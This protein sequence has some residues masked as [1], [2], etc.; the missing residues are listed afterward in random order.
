M[1]FLVFSAVILAALLDA[2][3]HV[4]IKGGA[5]PF[6]RS[7][8]VAIAGGVIA[9]PLL[10]YTGL[11]PPEAW[12]WLALS[13]CLGALYWIALGL[14]YQSGTLAAVFPLSRGAGVLLSA[15]GSHLWMAERLTAGATLVL[16]TILIGLML[17]STGLPPRH[18]LS[19]RAL[20]ASLCLGAIIGAFTLVD[21]VGVRVAGQ[22]LPY[23]L[24]LYV[25][26]ALCISLF[27]AVCQRRRM[28]SLPLGT[29]PGVALSAGLSLAAYALILFG[30]RHAPVALV[31]A[32]AETSLVFVAI[33][34]RVFL[35]EPTRP[36]QAFGL[37][38]VVAGVMML[39]L[40]M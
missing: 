28:A 5:D 18:G 35:A 13:V 10:V 4:L 2:L 30:F 26:N 14:A 34:G 25:G 23:C 20:L 37:F 7:L 1:Y 8:A 11:P 32:L 9:A 38:V 39:R 12:P 24:A 31:A 27:C 22:A 40:G 3:Q 6:A 21:A 33:L 15:A 17:I 19:P 16:V 36:T 29:G